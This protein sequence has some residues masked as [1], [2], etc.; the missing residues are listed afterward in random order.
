VRDLSL[1]KKKFRNKFL[2]TVVRDLS[3][4]KKKFR[5]KFLTT[6]FPLL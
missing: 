1:K 2:T 5:N 4:K 6:N 3:L